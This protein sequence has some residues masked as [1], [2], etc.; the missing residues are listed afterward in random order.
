MKAN[1]GELCGC[2]GG[3]NAVGGEA[4]NDTWTWNG[5]TWS[6]VQTPFTP[7][8][9]Y[10]AAMEYDPSL[11]GLVLFDGYFTGGPWTNQTWLFF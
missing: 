2:S 11:K 7:A 1:I 6:Q 8:G 3:Y 10:V 5:T 9:R 4:L